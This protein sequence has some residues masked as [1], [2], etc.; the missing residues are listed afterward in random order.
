MFLWNVGWLSTYYLW[1]YI[2]LL[3]LGRFFVS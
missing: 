1:L 2:P 3:D